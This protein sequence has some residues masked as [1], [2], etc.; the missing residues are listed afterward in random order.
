MSAPEAR[1]P[2]ATLRCPRD[3]TSLDPVAVGSIGIYRC[4]SCAGTWYPRDR[5]RMLKDR[6][7]HGDY[8]WID[9]DLWKEAQHFRLESEQRYR[10]PRDG[11]ALITVR[12]GEGNVAV[13]FC[14]EC[15][16]I[17]L[18]KGEYDVI[19][20]WLEKKVDSASI[21]DYLD[22]VREEL[23][24]VFTSG[25]G[26]VEE[27]KDLGKVL[28]LLELRFLLEHPRIERILDSLRLP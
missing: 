18:D 10:C 4:S 11:T 5:L 15:R 24:E 3:Q 12:Y 9:V 20:A 1:A 26:P 17:W 23:V 27:L 14:A 13:N 22:D 21:E 6:E 8:R 16:G 19:L 25:E 7:S 2:D 28:Y